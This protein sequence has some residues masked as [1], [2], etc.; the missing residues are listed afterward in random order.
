MKALKKFLASFPIDDG[1][2]IFLSST[3]AKVFNLYAARAG[4]CRLEVSLIPR[5]DSLTLIFRDNGKPVNPLEQLG[6]LNA[7]EKNYMVSGDENKLVV[8]F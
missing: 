7:R 2:K 5:D 3:V 4:I 8:K 6:T 1:R